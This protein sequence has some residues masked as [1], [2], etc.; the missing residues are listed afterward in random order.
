MPTSPTRR[1][2]NWATAPRDVI[3]T[4]PQTRCGLDEAPTSMPISSSRASTSARTTIL[5][6]GDKLSTRFEIDFFGSNLGS[7][8]VSNLCAVIRH[9]T[10]SG[11][12]GWWS[13]LVNFM[14]VATLPKPRLHWYG[15]TADLRRS[16]GALDEGGLSL[17]AENARPRSRLYGRVLPA[18]AAQPGVVQ[19]RRRLDARPH[20]TLRVER[21]VGPRG[22]RRLVRELVHE[23][24]GA[25][26]STTGINAPVDDSTWT[27]RS[28]CPAS[29]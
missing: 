18:P 8:N 11:A 14:D 29:S 20:G 12:A 28:A 23:S 19:L 27:A 10:C 16:A 1:T 22:R 13:D 24:T 9:A 3:S 15:R 2:V 21:L 6:G 17:S 5:E 25:Q 7:Q 26:F 4:F